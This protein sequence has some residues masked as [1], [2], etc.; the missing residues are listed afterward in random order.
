MK[1]QSL[2]TIFTIFDTNI[3]FKL[4]TEINS[5]QIFIQIEE[6][7]LKIFYLCCCYKSMSAKINQITHVNV[8]ETQFYNHII[9]PYGVE[10]V[11]VYKKI[12]ER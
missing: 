2:V 5:Q 8:M 1:G 10:S 11:N 3:Q 6:K 9:L 12:S 7:T 4:P